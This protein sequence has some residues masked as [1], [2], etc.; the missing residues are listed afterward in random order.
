[1]TPT[2]LRIDASARHAGS[3]SRALTQ[4]ILDRLAPDTVIER[5]LSVPLPPI[6]ETWFIASSTPQD[7]RSDDDRKTLSVSDTLIAEV[8]AAD[9]LV[10]G[11]PMYN[12]TVP[13]TLKTWLDQI[14]RPGITF[15]YLEDGPKG[16]L[17]GK[18]AIVAMASGGVPL[19]SDSDFLSTYL[20][21][22]LGFI[23]ITDVHFV[24]ADQLQINAEA[25]RAKANAAIEALAV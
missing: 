3:E 25:S 23:G 14:I 7:Q 17:T 6:D 5:D 20:R 10:I 15:N 22:I 4:R 19:G 13:A 11:A 18:R 9:I 12:F 24:V 16:L 1:M 8:Q 21:H 2:V